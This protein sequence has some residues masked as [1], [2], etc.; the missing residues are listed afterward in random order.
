MFF[1]LFTSIQLELHVACE[2]Q[3][4]AGAEEG[5][6]EAAND[7]ITMTLAAETAAAQ[8]EAE[9][10]AVAQEILSR[11]NATTSPMPQAVIYQC[12]LS[13]YLNVQY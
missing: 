4:D 3:E 1:L 6:A 9:A 12:M 5:H 11:A 13:S 7:S 10:E 8:P 2:L